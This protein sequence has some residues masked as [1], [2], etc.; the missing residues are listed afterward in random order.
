MESSL[1]RTAAE[2]WQ[3]A[4]PQSIVENLYGP[5]E[6]TIA[7]FLHRWDAAVS[8]DLCRN[9]CGSDWPAISRSGCSARRRRFAA[10]LRKGSAGELLRERPARR[11]GD[12]GAIPNEQPNVLCNCLP[13]IGRHAGIIGQVELCSTFWKTA[14][15]CSSGRTD[16]QIKVLGH[17]VELGEIEAA[18]RRGT[19]VE[20][21]IAVGWPLAES[22]AAEW[23]HRFRVR[24]RG[25]SKRTGG[26]CESRAAPLL[27]S[28]R[29]NFCG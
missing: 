17:R 8:P 3:A 6:L 12:T 19:G 20:H 26:T 21:A 7:C 22:G 1:T 10:G 5:T 18:L 4:A 13:T 27:R 24:G 25:R 9:G 28:T 14:N 2:A 15:M 23:H 29:N 11:H 16:D